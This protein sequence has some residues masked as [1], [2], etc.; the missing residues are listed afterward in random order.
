MTPG[1]PCTEWNPLAQ[2]LRGISKIAAITVVAP[3]I[4]VIVSFH[5]GP[6]GLRYTYLHCAKLDQ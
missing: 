2:S 1:V 4:S 5:S 3:N 6:S